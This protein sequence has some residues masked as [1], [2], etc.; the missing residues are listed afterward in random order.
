MLSLPRT[1][2]V[3]DAVR[4]A[5]NLAAKRGVICTLWLLG[6]GG[7]TGAEVVDGVDVR[8][9]GNPRPAIEAASRPASRI[10]AL[11]GCSEA[12]S[13]LQDWTP[14]RVESAAGFDRD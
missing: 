5:E 2:G 9:S 7:K 4:A 1:T 8:V 10:Y 12:I 14:L 13:E 6:G 11:P 3:P